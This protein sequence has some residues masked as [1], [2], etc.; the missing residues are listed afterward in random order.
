MKEERCNFQ[1]MAVEVDERVTGIH[2]DQL[3]AVLHAENV[4]ARRYFWPG[5]HRMEP[6][7]TLFPHASLSLPQ[8]ER[9]ADRI[10]VLPTGSTISG[11]DIEIVC[12]IL[13][14]GHCQCGRTL[15]ASICMIENRC[16]TLKNLVRPPLKHL[17]WG[18]KKNLVRLGYYA[19]PS[20]MILGA[21]KA[22][23]SALF[24]MLNQHPQVIGSHHK[25]LGFFISFGIQ[26]G[27]FLTYHSM[28]PMPH[29]LVSGKL[30]FEATPDYLY[31]TECP[32]K[33][34]SYSPDMLFVAI[35]RD[36]VA[37]AYSAWNMYRR[38]ASS[39][40]ADF[41]KLA[42]YRTFSDAVIDEMKVIEQTKWSNNSFAYVRRGVYVEQLQRYFQY[43]PHAACLIL[44]YQDLL[45]SP[46]V[47]LAQLCRFLKIDDAF[48]F[49]VEHRNISSYQDDMPNEVADMLHA[50]YAPH[51]ESLCSLL[52][53]EF[54]W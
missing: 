50:F 1:Y 2:R 31:C 26:Y 25:E 21:Q 4:L 6:Y 42:E 37:R 15:P 48:K 24:S 20:F 46:D 39:P 36:P 5:C 28:F 11:Q 7:R 29:R 19:K 51:N 47:C 54:K 3:I 13:A 8:T 17:Y 49:S 23:T 44:D 32:Q 40:N 41:R 53:R 34:Y 52:G 43:F 45:D 35:L 30:T 10:M 22:G 14:H 27:D 33:I 12:D 16:K 9:V 18:L 38:F